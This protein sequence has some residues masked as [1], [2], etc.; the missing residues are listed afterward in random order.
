MRVCILTKGEPYGWTRHYIRAFRQCCDEVLVAGPNITREELNRYNL[1]YLYESFTPTDIE[2][3]LRPDVMLVNL[4]PPGWDPDLIVAI[5]I[6]G[7]SLCPLF[8]H[9]RCP[10]VYLSIDTWQSPR[11]YLDAIAYDFVF[12]AQREFVPRL[13][14]MGARRVEW[15]P[16]ACDPAAHYPVPVTPT[17]D[18]SFAGSIA[19]PIHQER[20]DLVTRLQSEFVVN[21]RTSLYGHA[22]NR[23][24]RSGKLTF[25]HSAVRD[26]NMRVFEA[27]AMGVPLLTN[28]DAEANG[29]L[30][31]FNDG[32]HLVV[33][34]DADDLVRKV[35]AYARDD[36]ARAAIASA[37]R[38]EVLAV[39]TYR[40]R[41]E[42]VLATLRAEVPGFGSVEAE[43]HAGDEI[44]IQFPAAP[45]VVI[46]AGLRLAHAVEAMHKRGATAV[47]GA[48]TEACVADNRYDRIFALNSITQAGATDTFLIADIQALRVPPES[49]LETAHAALNEGG[50]LLIRATP[51]E[52]GAIG[53]DLDADHIRFWLLERDFL[54]VR[55]KVI[56]DPDSNV[57]SACVIVARKRTRL[58]A[59]VVSETFDALTPN[60]ESVRTSVLEWCQN[61]PQGI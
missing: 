15:L 38:A 46:D 4:L 51:A 20:H 22:L 9:T 58:L 32:E 53:M 43:P 26:L 17:S 60:C 14:S 3:E 27:L 54:F 33:Y 28:R 47:Y 21:A 36:D 6:G 19:L 37:G 7:I 2:T 11:D 8:E 39:H 1:G 42:A 59:D 25:N 56:L 45:G 52:L 30:D 57:P 24:C 49:A 61:F 41:V 10:K 29:L 44:I 35:R 5:S 18:V 23:F 16:L 48:A 13:R 12:A 55:A 50:T 40:H 31:L 34:D